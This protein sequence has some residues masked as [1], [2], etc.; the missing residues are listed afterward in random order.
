[1]NNCQE[2]LC[3]STGAPLFKLGMPACLFLVLSLLLQTP[4]W[5]S[6]FSLPSWPVLMGY[7][8]TSLEEVGPYNSPS[9]SWSIPSPATPFPVSSFS[10]VSCISLHEAKSLVEKVGSKEQGGKEE[11]GGEHEGKEGWRK[12]IKHILNTYQY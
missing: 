8:E 6:A 12:N 5:L 1:M 3:C 11:K 10:S 4:P 7:R 2:Q 9:S